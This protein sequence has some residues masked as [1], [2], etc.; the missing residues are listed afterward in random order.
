MR[1]NS[2]LSQFNNTEKRNRYLKCYQ[3]PKMFYC[4]L[5]KKKRVLWKR[6][7]E[8]HGHT[9]RFK[10]IGFVNHTLLWWQHFKVNSVRGIVYEET[11][12]MWHRLYIST[13]G[14]L[15]WK[16]PTGAVFTFSIH[17]VSLKC[18]SRIQVLESAAIF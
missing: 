13:I 3:R 4:L 14:L 7:G 10:I 17:A 8:N 11:E 9:F 2:R 5:S 12:R 1:Q 16:Y 6:T 18:I 15:R